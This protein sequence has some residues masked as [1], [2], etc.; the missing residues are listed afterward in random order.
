M[1][2]IS[3]KPRNMLILSAELPLKALVKALWFIVDQAEPLHLRNVVLDEQ[4][5]SFDIYYSISFFLYVRIQRDV[6]RTATAS[7]DCKA[8]P[9]SF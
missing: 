3:A 4:W 5:H 6:D 1:F 7:A 9:V 2:I 8:D